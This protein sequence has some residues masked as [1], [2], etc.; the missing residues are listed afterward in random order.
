MSCTNLP[1][2]AIAGVILLSEI[3]GFTLILWACSLR[4]P[5]VLPGRKRKP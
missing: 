2:G 5:A 4:F 3:V 1:I